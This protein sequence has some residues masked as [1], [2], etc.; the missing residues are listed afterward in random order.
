MRAANRSTSAAG[1]RAAITALVLSLLAVVAAADARASDYVLRIDLGPDVAALGSDDLAVSGPAADRLAALAPAVLPLLDTALRREDPAVRLGV[2]GVLQQVPGDA[3]VA[4]LVRAAADRD[5]AVRAEALL[6]LGLRG[7]TAGRAVVEGAL[8]DPDARARRAA[9][10]ACHA[11]C[12]SPE[13]LAALVDLAVRDAEA[14]VAQRSLAS[15][16]ANG[17]AARVAAARAAVERRALPVL[18]ATDVGERERFNAALVVAES[19][20]RE[21]VPVLAAVVVADGP[22]GPGTQA[23]LALGAVA[24]PQAVAALTPAAA[25][26]QPALRIAACASLRR[27]QQQAVAG[28]DAALAGCPAAGR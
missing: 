20:R 14:P 27:L 6:A 4:L 28:A 25:S 24:D 9:A 17:D 15:L 23:A 19:G 18:A 10:A 2:V 1:H 13:A 22:P 7:E 12:A 26:P 21:A 11:L 3:A 8:A 16:L 5:A